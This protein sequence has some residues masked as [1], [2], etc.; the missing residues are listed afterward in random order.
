MPSPSLSPIPVR[1]RRS[2]TVAVGVDLVVGGGVVGIVA[3]I[4]CLAVTFR[5]HYG[6]IGAFAVAVVIANA[7]AGG[8]VPAHCKLLSS[9]SSMVVLSPITWQ[10]MPIWIG[11]AGPLSSQ[12]IT[13]AN[14]YRCRYR[15]YRYKR[16]RPAKAAL[17]GRVAGLLG[18]GA[19][20]IAA[21]IAYLGCYWG[22]YR[23]SPA[24]RRCH[25]HPHRRYRYRRRW[26]PIQLYYCRGHHRGGIVPSSQAR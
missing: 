22:H 8:G 11:I 23:H 13:S 16:G 2:G 26:T 18:G 19:V 14:N 7:A 21:G 4:A 12:P 9:L 6:H 24:R 25:H 17:A 20:A 5:Y 3:G 1:C 10:V 15:R